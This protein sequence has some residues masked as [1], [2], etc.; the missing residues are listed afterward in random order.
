MII[1]GLGRLRLCTAVICCARCG[2]YLP[3]M[4]RAV[5][6]VVH[7]SAMDVHS[8]MHGYLT[9]SVWNC[10]CHHGTSPGRPFVAADGVCPVVAPDL[11]GANRAGGLGEVQDLAHHALGAL[12]VVPPACLT[13]FRTCP[14]ELVRHVLAAPKAMVLRRSLKLV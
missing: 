10:P 8:S 1:R 6:D 12:Y 9:T 7:A 11:A 3:S 5:S 14:V 13:S 4:A 2:P